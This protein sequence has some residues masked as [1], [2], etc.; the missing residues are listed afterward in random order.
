MRAGAAR[1]VSCE[2][3]RVLCGGAARWDCRRNAAQ[4]KRRKEMLPATMQFPGGRLVVPD[5]GAEQRTDQARLPIRFTI[6]AS[7]GA[8]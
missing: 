2:A 4:S 6:G 7:H 3:R 8:T 1:L 5:F